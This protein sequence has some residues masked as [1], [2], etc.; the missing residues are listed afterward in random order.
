[1]H[2]PWIRWTVNYSNRMKSFFSVP[3]DC[4]QRVVVDAQWTKT[5]SLSLNFFY[6]KIKNPFDHVKK[7]WEIPQLF[8]LSQ[9][10]YI[11]YQLTWCKDVYPY[12][13][14]QTQHIF[15]KI[16]L[17]FFVDFLKC[18]SHCTETMNFLS[19]VWEY[20]GICFHLFFWLMAFSLWCNS[21]ER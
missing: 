7:I 18:L 3:S 6:V 11:E 1:M 15:Q 5:L 17:L 4:I 2:Q 16:K 19:Y 20:F 12:T 9:N 13:G 10:F 14:H 21:G 8:Q